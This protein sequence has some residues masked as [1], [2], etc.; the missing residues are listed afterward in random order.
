MYTS[1]YFSDTNAL[2]YE[3]PPLCSFA[4]TYIF[5]M[6]PFLIILKYKI[7]LYWPPF[8]IPL[9]STFLMCVLNTWTLKSQLCCLMFW[10]RVN[11][12]RLIGRYACLSSFVFLIALR[13]AFLL[14]WPFK[15]YFIDFSGREVSL[16]AI[17]VISF[18]A[19]V[20]WLFN[21]LTPPCSMHFYPKAA[22]RVKEETLTGRGGQFFMSVSGVIVWLRKLVIFENTCLITESCIGLEVRRPGSSHTSDT[23][24]KNFILQ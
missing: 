19:G 3:R 2:I 15:K 5:Y 17:P 8:V 21:A 14:E 12:L 10:T 11:S 1:F 23:E 9:A 22:C 13:L 7:R 16:N 20:P 24:Q 6:K 18:S 4:L